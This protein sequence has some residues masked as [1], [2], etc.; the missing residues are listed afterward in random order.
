MPPARL[1][2]TFAALLGRCLAALVSMAK[3]C[4]VECGKGPEGGGRAITLYAAAAGRL[5]GLEAA[6]AAA[7]V[8]AEG[9]GVELT[10]ELAAL[11]AAAL[12]VGAALAR[13]REA[14]SERGEALIDALLEASLPFLPDEGGEAA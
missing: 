2:A 6:W 11:R 9:A 12:E 8:T 7:G 10:P 1:A 3:W 13:R 5:H 4:E 14:P